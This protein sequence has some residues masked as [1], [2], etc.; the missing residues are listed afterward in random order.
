MNGHNDDNVAAGG[1]CEILTLS[2]NQILLFLGVFL[3]V[4]AI[5]L[6]VWYYIG[7]W[8]QNLV[9]G[10]A[11]LVLLAMGYHPQEIAALELSDAYLVNFNLVPLIA[12]TVAT[13]K[14]LMKKR[15][16]ILAAGVPI[17]LFIHVLDIVVRFPMYIYH[18][19]L[20]KLIYAA[21]GVAWMAVPFIIW[22]AIA[23][24][25]RKSR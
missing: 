19:E 9:F 11:R 17:L 15:L 25:F 5:L 2:V 20:A 23:L 22:V 10:I 3:A 12:L 7:I 16:E 14:L 6:A 21:I 8:Y 18:S 1:R 13:P 4:S 24:S